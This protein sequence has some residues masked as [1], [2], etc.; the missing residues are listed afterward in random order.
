MSSQQ[1][2]PKAEAAAAV[3][4]LRTWN[5]LHGPRQVSFKIKITLVNNFDMAG[6]TFQAKLA[7]DFQWMLSESEKL[8]WL[9]S[10]LGFTAEWE[11]QDVAIESAIDMNITRSKV[12]VERCENMLMAKQTQQVTGTFLEVMELHNFPFDCQDISLTMV[13]AE[14]DE[15]F[16][17]HPAIERLDCVTMTQ[18]TK[19]LPS[20]T[21]HD[22]IMELTTTPEVE[23]Q[24]DFSV[25]EI[26]QPI[27]APR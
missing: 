22:P 5:K 24:P 20:Y 17:L 2:T 7:I 15:N 9:H 23:M 21:F 19:L 1:F 14:S 27:K 16:H 12:I 10:Y 26:R 25:K 8:A 3:H 6:Q 18:D 11:P 13:F 4:K